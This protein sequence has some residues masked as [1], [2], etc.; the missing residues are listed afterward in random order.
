MKIKTK[1]INAEEIKLYN[2]GD[3]HYG[4]RFCERDKF[5]KVVEMIKNDDNAYWVSTGDLLE[6]SLASSKIYDY[7]ALGTQRELRELTEIL[8]P[9]SH[10]CLGIT[11]SNHHKRIEIVSGLNLDEI[12]AQYLNIEALGKI[13][14][15]NIMVNKVAYFLTMFHGYGAG[16]S[17]GAKINMLS[18]FGNTIKGFDIYLAGHTHCFDYTINVEQVIDK[19]HKKVQTLNSHYCITGHY[20]KWFGSYASEKMFAPAPCGSTVVRLKGGEHQSQ[21]NIQIYFQ[22]V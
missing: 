17:K 10:K 12:I 18:N 4:S 20:I 11:E 21:K 13:G 22:E 3:V 5:L 19:K 16:R 14:F 7:E 1:V 15:L 8:K 6:I 9:V 2:L